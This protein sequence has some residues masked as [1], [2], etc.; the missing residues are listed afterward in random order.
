MI[1]L[2]LLYVILI[3]R[4][5]LAKYFSAAVTKNAPRNPIILE[6]KNGGIWQIA[7]TPVPHSYQP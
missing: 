7:K 3:L 5:P 6:V 1:L 4:E 2:A